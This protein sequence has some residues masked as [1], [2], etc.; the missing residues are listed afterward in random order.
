MTSLDL[1]MRKLSLAQQRILRKGKKIKS[2]VLTDDD[3]DAL[4]NSIDVVRSRSAKKPHK[5]TGR[6]RIDINKASV[7]EL[8]ARGCL[9]SEIAAIL[10]ISV[11]TLE[12]RITNEPGFKESLQAGRDRGKAELRFLQNHHATGEGSAAVKM[13]IHL[14]QHHL[15][16]HEQKPVEAKQPLNVQIINDHGRLIGKL[17]SIAKRIQDGQHYIDVTPNSVIEREPGGNLLGA[18]RVESDR[19]EPDEA[20]TA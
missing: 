6:K 20:G 4:Q 7:E 10:R 16:E 5:K 1:P 14:S 8:A 15:G 18:P 17:E 3:R 13:T 2:E 11:A 12:D 19:P 9:N